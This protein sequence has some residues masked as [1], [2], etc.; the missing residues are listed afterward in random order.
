[1]GELIVFYSLAA[2]ICACSVAVVT[3]RNP[4]A[5]AIF[6]VLDLFLIAGVYA[7]QNA[8]F[9]AAVQVIVYAGAIVV[10]FLFVIMLLNLTP[11][12][13]R[14]SRHKV[15]EYMVMLVL[16]VTCVIVGIALLVS[17]PSG[18]DKTKDVL[19]KIG[20]TEAIGIELFA[21]YI[22]PFELASILI[23]LAIIASIV[24]AKKDKPTGLLKQNKK[25][26]F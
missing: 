13:L 20:N 18:V 23:L 4:V 17:G 21:N 22:W 25:G 2:L 9:V 8:H 15:P 7:L 16:A 3:F 1:M 14:H 10:L 11:N 24:I 26:V 6:L 12:D 19:D 5:A